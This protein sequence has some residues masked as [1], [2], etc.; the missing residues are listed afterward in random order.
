MGR[1]LALRLEGTALHNTY[2]NKTLA[3]LPDSY[4]I[5]ALAGDTALIGLNVILATAVK[6]SPETA[7][8][9]CGFPCRNP[10]RPQS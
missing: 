5:D 1:I 6:Q 7:S 10:F 8:S 4:E 3:G 9:C 2:W